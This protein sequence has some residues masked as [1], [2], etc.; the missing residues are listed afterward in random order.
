MAYSS[1]RAVVCGRRRRL[2]ELSAGYSG[3]RALTCPHSVLGRAVRSEARGDPRPAALSCTETG[4]RIGEMMGVAAQKSCT[5]QGVEYGDE[6]CN[7][8]PSDSGGH[9]I[10]MRSSTRIH[11]RDGC[12]L[13]IPG[14]VHV[15][16]RS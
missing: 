3:T 12:G 8:M 10:G 9:A 16:I 7:P 1:P 15:R 2:G 5:R 14:S 4:E 11:V 13:A 6:G